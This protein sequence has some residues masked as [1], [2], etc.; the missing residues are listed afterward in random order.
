[1]RFVRIIPVTIIMA[2]LLLTVKIIDVVRGTEALSEMLLI[3][4]VQAEQT[5]ED[6]KAPEGGDKKEAGDKK[7]GDKPAADAKGA[8]KAGDKKEGDKKDGDKKDGEKKEEKKDDKKDKNKNP[9][10]SESVGTV[11]DRFYSASEVEI[12]KNLAKR[13][14][15]LDRWERNIQVKESALNATEKRIADKIEQI[16]AMKK[17]VSELLAQYN[18]QEDAK[19]RSLVKIYENMKP[20]EAARIFD[21]IDMPILLLVIDKMAEKKAAPILAEMEPRKAK[22]I[23]VELAEQRRLDTGKLEGVKKE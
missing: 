11:T 1:M 12:L 2:V 21:E 13:R 6:A 5:K 10:V 22:Q 16:N 3:T 20:K 19:I 17:E 7:E 23:T 8:D 18:A 14:E 9:N 4:K 15:D